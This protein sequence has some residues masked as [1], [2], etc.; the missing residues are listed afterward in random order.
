MKNAVL[1]RFAVRRFLSSLVTA[2]PQKPFVW[3]LLFML[4]AFVQT[5]AQNN[6]GIN[7]TTPHA[8]AALDISSTTQGMLTPRMTQAQRTAIASP[9]T[10]LLV[11]QTDGTAGFYFYNG[12]SWT[13][14]AVTQS[15]GLGTAKDANGTVLGVVVA[16]SNFAVTVR[17]STGYFYEIGYDG[18]PMKTGLLFGYGGFAPTTIFY[19]NAGCTGQ[20]YVYAIQEGV[21]GKS[22][23]YNPQSGQFYTFSSLD[24]NNL[25]PAGTYLAYGSYTYN[26][27]CTDE[28]Y[29]ANA[30]VQPV[31]PITRAAAGIPSTIV[32]PITIQ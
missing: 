1:P 26:G 7:T 14:L 9:A 15:A 32:A 30:Y 29:G 27:N 20:A 24:A 3:F 13:A 31:T 19:P 18:N 25:A 28:I 8:S 5:R 23:I 17:S 22:L 21:N 10:G 16:L 12:S 6:V 11:Y 4:T 2:T